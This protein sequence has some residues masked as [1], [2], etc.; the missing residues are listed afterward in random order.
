M[1]CREC[2]ALRF[3]IEPYRYVATC[4]ALNDSA[5]STSRPKTLL[6]NVFFCTQSRPP[7]CQGGY[8]SRSSEERLHAGSRIRLTPDRQR[9]SR[10]FGPAALGSVLLFKYKA[11]REEKLWLYN[12]GGISAV[13]TEN[14]SGV[15]RNKT[16]V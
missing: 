15:K 1:S 5:A 7:S 12:C 4:T 9:P 8:P 2:R 11:D 3:V 6:T 13:E 16:I 10:D 14:E